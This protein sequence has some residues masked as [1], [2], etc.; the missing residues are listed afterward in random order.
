MAGG[1]A[2]PPEESLHPM[3]HV[4]PLPPSLLPSLLPS[5]SP[6]FP[7]SFPPSLPLFLP[8]S[9]PLS[10]SLSPSLPLSLRLNTSLSRSLSL[11]LLC[12]QA[13]GG[14]R[15]EVDGSLCLA[16]PRGQEACGPG[17][18]PPHPPPHPHRSH[19]PP[20]RLLPYPEARSMIASRVHSFIP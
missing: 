6:S 5:L 19:S 8:P 16:A 14:C 4:R 12:S 17:P 20:A 10:P 15:V 1:A 18:P 11:A 9:L 2:A 13:V 3:G 7:P